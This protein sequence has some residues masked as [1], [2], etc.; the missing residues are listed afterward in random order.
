[1]T[2]LPV[3]VPAK[4]HY[5]SVKYRIYYVENPPKKFNDILVMTSLPVSVPV[6]THYISVKYRIYYAKNHPPKKSMI[7]WLWHHYQY[8]FLLKRIISAENTVYTMRKINQKNQ[9]YTDY[10]IITSI[11]S[12]QNALYQRKIPYILCGKSIPPKKS[13]IYW[14]WHHYHSK[15]N[16]F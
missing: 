13:M 7:Y 6:K 14:L 5:I 9:W 11:S 15:E 10:D 2:S 1:M 16:L 3:S 12:C 4:T 8:Q